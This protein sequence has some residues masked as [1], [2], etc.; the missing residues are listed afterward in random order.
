MPTV[1]FEGLYNIR[2]WSIIY[3][4]N[5]IYWTHLREYTPF[6]L[7]DHFFNIEMLDS[8]TGCIVFPCMDIA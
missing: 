2:L 4:K 7:S 6:L 5:I 1:F 3:W 8:F